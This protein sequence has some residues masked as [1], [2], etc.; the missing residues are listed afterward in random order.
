[1][2][3]G[4][5][6]IILPSLFF[7]FMIVFSWLFFYVIRRKKETCKKEMERE[8]ISNANDIDCGHRDRTESVNE[9][10]ERRN[11][12]ELTE[13]DWDKLF[14]YDGVEDEGP[15]YEEFGNIGSRKEV[16]S[17]LIRK[18]GVER[19]RII[20]TKIAGITYEKRQWY[21]KQCDIGQKLDLIRDACNRYDKNAVAVF[22]ENNQI[23]FLP[24]DIACRVAPQIDMG[25]K[26]E[27]YVES[28]TRG[29]GKCYSV[30]IVVIER[31]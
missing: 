12:Q 6:R 23:G 29:V 14:I 2:S 15:W 21:V 10:E 28:V 13:E 8:L 25:T 19:D 4:E 31:Q 17:R 30:G 16:E 7:F 11:S 18:L 9:I 5:G 1:M 22:L 27:C 24:R 26:V 20:F 3:I